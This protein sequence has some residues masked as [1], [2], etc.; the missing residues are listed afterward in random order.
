MRIL[1]PEDR[2]NVCVCIYLGKTD[3]C[4]NIYEGTSKV[5]DKLNLVS[6]F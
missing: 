5:H 4:T 6:S 2:E 1:R 3:L